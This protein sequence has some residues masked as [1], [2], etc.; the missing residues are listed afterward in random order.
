MVTQL[1]EVLFVHT[2][3]GTRQLWEEPTLLHPGETFFNRSPPV[4][5][6]GTG[7]ERV[8]A[9]PR[10]VGPDLARMFWCREMVFETASWWRCLLDRLG[11]IPATPDQSSPPPRTRHRIALA[12]EPDGDGV[13]DAGGAR[14]FLEREEAAWRAWLGL[15]TES[16]TRERR[17]VEQWLEC[18]SIP[19]E[20]GAPEPERARLLAEDL[21]A[22]VRPAFGFWLFPLEVFGPVDESGLLPLEYSVDDADDESV[23]WSVDRSVDWSA[24]WPELALVSLPPGPREARQKER[25]DLNDGSVLNN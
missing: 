19:P 2:L 7:L 24:H 5:A 12:A 20:G 3:R 16:Q 22:A 15:E 18:W 13:A 21:D 17:H 8:A 9:D 10:N 25:S 6:T 11:V 14:A 1:R 23:G 4:M